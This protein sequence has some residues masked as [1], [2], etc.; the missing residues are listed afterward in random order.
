MSEKRFICYPHRPAPG[1]SGHEV[2]AVDAEHAALAYVPEIWDQQRTG[3][4]EVFVRPYG[5]SEIVRVDCFARLQLVV[6]LGAWSPTL[7]QAGESE[8]ESERRLW[9]G[10]DEES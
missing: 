3:R 5:S 2:R 8:D 4:V 7:V 6:E 10:T 1:E 9:S